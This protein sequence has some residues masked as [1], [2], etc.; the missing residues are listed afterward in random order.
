MGNLPVHWKFRN[1]RRA[2]LHFVSG[3][4]NIIRSFQ[5]ERKPQINNFAQAGGAASMSDTL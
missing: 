1:A 2:L 5:K 3:Q 4:D